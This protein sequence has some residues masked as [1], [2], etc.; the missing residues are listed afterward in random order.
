MEVANRFTNAERIPI[1]IKE[2]DHPSMTDQEDTITRD[3]GL[4]TMIAATRA[5]K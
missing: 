3:A 2:H 4:A 5:I 1:T